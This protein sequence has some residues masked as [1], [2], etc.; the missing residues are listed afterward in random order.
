MPTNTFD[1]IPH[2]LTAK[3]IANNFSQEEELRREAAETNKN[4]YYG[5][6][7]Q[8]INLFSLEVEPMSVNYTRPVVQKRSTM[9]Y[10]QKLTR[11]ITGPAKSISILEQ[12]YTDNDLDALM[13][14]VDLLSELTGSVLVM[15]VIDE[16]L[17]GRVKL[18]MWDGA[19][20]SVV[21]DE[22]D[23][24]K[25]AA[26]SLVK[27]IDK[28]QKGWDSGNPQSERVLQQQIWTDNQVVLYQGAELMVSETNELG[29][30]PF[31]NFQGEEVYGQYVGYAPGSIVRKLNASINQKLTDLSYTIKLQAATPVVMTGYQSGEDM[32]VSP[33]RAMSLPVGADAK[34]LDLDPK[35]KETL[36]T[37]MYLEEKIY[38]T[39]SVPKITIMGGEGVSGR[40][41][42]VR[43]YPLTQVF[44]EKS[45]RF[46]KYELE[47]ANMILKVLGEA[48]VEF[49]K[50]DFP[51]EDNLP[52]SPEF[53][54]LERDIRL[55]LT[56][57][58]E[59]LMRVNTD[60][61]HDEAKKKVMENVK[62]TEALPDLEEQTVDPK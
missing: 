16:N 9:L 12:V 46:E 35:I 52:F 10:N 1:S 31:V 22:D 20:I 33:G 45:V 27:V 4:Y 15:P 13:L 6:T 51:D 44:R 59:E 34:V 8:Y 58:S 39:S 3:A 57:P 40:E 2:E 11:D 42:L 61:T 21:S 60:L 41:L 18:K 5:N 43:W 29:F 54:Y 49:M 55:G 32:I 7:T 25:P 17:E 37:I 53:E 56:S 19:G 36:E 50:I 28:L 47:L 14:Q 30:L 48:P 26:I 24:N 38:D 23:T 62:E